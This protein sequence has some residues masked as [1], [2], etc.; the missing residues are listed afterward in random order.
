[1]RRS[2]G[3]GRSSARDTPTDK[4]AKGKGATSGRKLTSMIP[5]GTVNDIQ[6]DGHEDEAVEG[7][8][9]AYRSLGKRKELEAKENAAREE[10]KRRRPCQIEDEDEDPQ[11]LREAEL[12]PV[13]DSAAE[14]QGDLSG[15]EGCARLADGNKKGVDSKSAQPEAVSNGTG[16][17]V[18]SP[19]TESKIV[20]EEGAP[21]KAKIN[22]PMKADDKKEEA[23]EMAPS[24]LQSRGS[25]ED[26]GLQEL[27]VN[28]KTL[29]EVQQREKQMGFYINSNQAPIMVN[30]GTGEMQIYLRL[31]H[32]YWKQYYATNYI[33]ILCIC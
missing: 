29:L 28:R 5:L 7:L 11:E 6:T 20:A 33:C 31:E 18:G 32:R 14:A 1:M 17:K 16:A 10:V 22:E 13:E 26:L 30:K 21:M 23:T 25:L 3:R 9:E 12:K 15:G 24:G 27:A 4:Q 8:N 2:S 19:T